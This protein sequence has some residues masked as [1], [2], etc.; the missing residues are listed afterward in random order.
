MK[1]YEMDES[2]RE[3]LQ[4]KVLNYVKS[5]FHID[6]TVDEWHKTLT[7]VVENW[8]NTYKAWECITL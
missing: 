8:R 4:E 7:D 2:D 5:E 1:L 6:S 3:K